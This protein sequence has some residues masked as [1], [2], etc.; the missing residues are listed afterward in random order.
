VAA[1]E[2]RYVTHLD[3]ERNLVVLGAEADL[4]TD[5]CAVEDLH[6]G[7]VA[8]ISEP[9]TVSAKYRYKT[10][11]ASAIVSPDRDGLLRVRFNQP[12]RAVTP[13]QS[14]VFYDGD[15]VVGGGVI[16]ATG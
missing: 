15:V 10:P 9:T 3:S 14:I 5:T 16:A 7:A 6:L 8:E 13:G 12:Q 2:R 1:G 11:E 4:Y